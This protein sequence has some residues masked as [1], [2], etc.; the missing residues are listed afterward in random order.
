MN[1]SPFFY[2]FF[3]FAPLVIGITLAVLIFASLINHHFENSTWY[4]FMGIGFVEWVLG[5]A[6]MIFFI[7]HCLNNPKLV[8]NDRLLWMLFLVIGSGLTPIFYWW[9][10]IRKT[11]APE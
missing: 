11:N 3:A 1:R 4:I 6:A 10:H 8:G 5:F 7:L 9:K 2:A